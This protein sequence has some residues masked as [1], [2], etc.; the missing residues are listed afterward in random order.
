[1]TDKVCIISPTYNRRKFL[2]YLIYQFNYQIYP[3]ELLTLIILDDSDVSNQDLFDTIYDENLRSRIIY[4]HDTNK[5]P[6]GAKRN[7]L[8]SIVKSIGTDY[9]V[10]FDDDD[11][12]P[13]TKIS[14][15]INQLKNSHYLIGGIS[16]ILIY[17]PQVNQLYRFGKIIAKANYLRM[18]Y[19]DN[20]IT[21]GTFIYK[22]KYLDN[23]SYDDKAMFAEESL[24]MDFYK[25]RVFKFNLFNYIMISHNSNTID[26]LQFISKGVLLDYKL[27][28]IISDQFL[29]NFYLNLK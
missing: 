28:D 2:P 11:Y 3:K 27:S 4:I 10:C 14:I 17:Y 25:F 19:L 7:I 15:D 18:K 8:N 22:F 9:V 26:K 6:I 29:L 23:H 21:N 24:F 20:D 16:P 12:Y 1:M 13:N 5:K